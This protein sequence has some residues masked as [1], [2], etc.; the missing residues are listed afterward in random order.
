MKRRRIKISATHLLTCAGMLIVRFTFVI[1]V[2]IACTSCNPYKPMDVVD[3]D[4]L[5]T[6]VGCEGDSLGEISWRIYCYKYD[7]SPNC[8]GEEEVNSY[9]DWYVGSEEESED[10]D[11]V[12]CENE[13]K[14]VKFV[15]RN[16]VTNVYTEE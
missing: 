5:Q 7:V 2:I 9:L 8:P 4:P 16:G 10:L 12:L 3:S 15:K 1:A 13:K 6:D 14:H 11:S